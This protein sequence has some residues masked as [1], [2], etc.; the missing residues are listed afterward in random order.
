MKTAF[1]I[2]WKRQPFDDWIWEQSYWTLAGK[3][4]IVVL[5]FGTKNYFSCCW[6]PKNSCLGV[7]SQSGWRRLIRL[8]FRKAC[9]CHSAVAH[10][11]LLR[12]KTIVYAVWTQTPFFRR[13]DEK[14]VFFAVSDKDHVSWC[15]RTTRRSS[16]WFV[17]AG[18]R[19]YNFAF[20]C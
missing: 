18:L 1:F 4:A 8:I 13:L 17:P 12:P 16:F 5:L 20:D 11:P 19:G 6:Y 9:C 10:S 15:I 3:R 14:V 7:W 2:Q